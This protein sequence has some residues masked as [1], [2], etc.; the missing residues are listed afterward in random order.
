MLENKKVKASLRE[1]VE[2]AQANKGEAA[3]AAVEIPVKSVFVVTGQATDTD[4]G[5][6]GFTLGQPALDHKGELVNRIEMHGGGWLARAA[7]G[8]PLG[9]IS[10]GNSPYQ[11]TYAR[12]PQAEKALKGGK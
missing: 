10:P 2:K 5:A 6:I 9:Y 4:A 8:Y 11:V 7:D 1:A 3:P 12:D